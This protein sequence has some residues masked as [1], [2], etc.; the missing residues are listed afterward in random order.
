LQEG[1]NRIGNVKEEFAL[2]RLIDNRKPSSIRIVSLGRKHEEP[3]RKEQKEEQGFGTG[4]FQ[5]QEKAGS[6]CAGQV[7]P[8]HG[9]IAGLRTDRKDQLSGINESAPRQK[10]D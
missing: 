1:P 2:D 7:R 8:E 9:E 3:R 4:V 5:E 10:N 6:R